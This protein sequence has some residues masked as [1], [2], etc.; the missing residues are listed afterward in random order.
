MLYCPPRAASGGKEHSASATSAQIQLLTREVQR[1]LS[2]MGG[3]T[4]EN[5]K[6]HLAKTSK[7]ATELTDAELQ[8]ILVG[9]AVYVK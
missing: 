4:T 9:I 2:E 8:R 3:V 1:L 7:D 5:I 6:K